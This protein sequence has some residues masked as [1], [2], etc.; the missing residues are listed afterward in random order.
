MLKRSHI[1][2]YLFPCHFYLLSMIWFHFHITLVSFLKLY[3]T[4]HGYSL[5][6]TFAIKYTTYHIYYIRCIKH[7]KPTLL[8]T[9]IEKKT[10]NT[11]L[12]F[13]QRFQHP[14]RAL[15]AAG[16]GSLS[17]RSAVLYLCSLSSLI[18]SGH[19]SDYDIHLQYWRMQDFK[20][21]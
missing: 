13:N 7:F 6:L 20:N 17:K 14:T 5:S 3:Y 19:H 15:D 2:F 11:L 18:E 9:L 21:K 12:F 16:A 10:K 1:L 4:V 8:F